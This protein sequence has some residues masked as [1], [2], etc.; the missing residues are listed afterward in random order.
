MSTNHTEAIYEAARNIAN[1]F[2]CSFKDVVLALERMAYSTPLA[3]KEM[4]E[5]MAALSEQI[6]KESEEAIETLAKVCC[7]PY[8]CKCKSGYSTK[9]VAIKTYWHRVRSFCVR[10]K[11]H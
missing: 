3:A 10:K 6:E 9:P 8:R 7:P 4:R 1:A 5:V 2:G 11:H